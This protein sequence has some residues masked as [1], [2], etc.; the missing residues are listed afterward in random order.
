VLIVGPRLAGDAAAKISSPLWPHEQS[1][2][3]PDR[4]VVFGRLPNG[5]RYALR[6][7]QKPRDRV[8]LHLVVNAG[9]I[10][11]TD[12]Q[13]GIAHFLEH[14][15]F[16]GSTHFPP[17]ELVKYFQKIGMQFGPDANASTSFFQTVYDINLP[18]GDRQSLEEALLVMGD[19]AEGA[20]LLQSEID[21]EREVVLAEKRTRDSAD[22]RT[23]KASMAFELEGTLFP[24]R[25]PIGTEAIIRQA[26]RAVFKDFYDTWYRPDNMVLVMVGDFDL[27]L[28]VDLIADRFGDMSPR[29]G[30]E[31]L[32][33][34]ATGTLIPPKADVFYHHEAE[35]GSTTLTIQVL[36]S[37][38]R[39]VDS[40]DYKKERLEDRLIGMILQNRLERLL[41][42]PDPPFTEAS[43]GIGTFL[44]QIRYG[45][46]S[47]ECPPENWK[48]ALATIETVRR[49]ALR[50]GFDPREVERVRKD[51]LA[52]LALHV[53]Q[54]ATRESKT[55]ARGLIRTIAADR[56]YQS[57]RQEK[58][59]Y[60]P[61]LA[62]LSA[63]TLN[64]RLRQV[65]AMETPKIL[66]TG[67]TNLTTAPEDAA[68]II[69]DVYRAAAE[70][71]VEAPQITQ[72]V[73]FP[74][75][76][77]P[78]APR[79]RPAAR[80]LIEDL[81]ITRVA[82]PNGIHLVLKPTDF[83]DNEI[84]FALSFEG[85]R[86]VE[87]RDRPGLAELSRDVINESGVGPLDR[88]A[89]QVALTGKTTH[90]SFDFSNDRF[91]FE[92]ATSPKEIQL[93]FQL[94]HAHLIDPAFRPA[95][96]HLAQE[97]FA[98]AHQQMAQSIDG[99]FRLEG[100]RFLSGGDPRFGK[101]QLEEFQRLRLADVE[102]WVKPILAQSPLEL[103]LVGDFDLETA[104]AL[105]Q[106]Y[107]GGL[108]ARRSASRKAGP[109][110]VFPAG[111]QHR[112][113]VGTQIDKALLVLAFLTDDA[114]DIQRTRRLNVLADVFS[115][116]LREEIREK[117]GAAYSPGAYSWP[118]RAY[119]GFGLFL[120][121]LP[122][123][124]GEVA[125][126][127]TAVQ[128]IARKIAAEGIRPPELQR[129]LEPTLTGIREQ[130]RQNRYWLN[131]VLAG[132][133]GRP[134]QIEWSRTIAADYASIQAEEL[135]ALAQRYLDPAQAAVFE[136]RP[137]VDSD[138]T[139]AENPSG[140]DHL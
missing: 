65:W 25:L 122:V 23:Y 28:A 110:P 47:A 121:Y 58:E 112:M 40:A 63:E 92:G 140:K 117:R 5:L 127:L 128:D 136:A 32:P 77:T 35:L 41:N 19:Y 8:S 105:A 2:L 55:L 97:R 14:M 34:I 91:F 33:V 42:R 43:A 83:S 80:E 53:D 7:N 68:R 44:R 50:Y 86:S 87:P 29:R 114:R 120:A 38:P 118:S 11:E 24:R 134:E 132:S 78:S 45:Y 82:L 1:D 75:L 64:G 59:F 74:Y 99:A 37:I 76:P 60:A 15:L 72:S 133:T 123:A 126:V 13:Q 67:N 135:V 103:S 26:D 56:V 100:Y 96:Y 70:Q 39:I 104:I 30:D 130:L 89:L 81:G 137:Q 21:R 36:K 20:L 27:N 16:N 95:A 131:T 48:A 3:A 94:L 129:A 49:Q 54:A 61:L 57:P 125:P 119:P 12:S 107:L 9:S 46:I 111:R 10:N 52:E 115:D 106:Q 6:H 88:E 139:R 71:P 124:P 4:D 116:R 93:L 90:L 98:Q 62:S 22:Y 69:Q 84:L 66:M 138:A 17:G 101:P 79:G 51:F 109:G 73:K 108:P 18:Q 31:A 102:R 113:D 85:G